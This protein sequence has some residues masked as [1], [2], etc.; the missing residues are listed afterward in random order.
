[1][2]ERMANPIVAKVLERHSL[3]QN[4]TSFC[5]CVADVLP[6][7]HAG[8]AELTPDGQYFE[9]LAEWSVDHTEIA[10]GRRFPRAGTVGDAVLRQSEHFVGPTREAVRAFPNTAASLKNGGFQSNFVARVRDTP[11]LVL[12][13]LSRRV[14]ALTQD[15]VAS[16][17]D[18]LNHLRELLDGSRRLAALDSYEQ[19]LQRD[20]ASFLSAYS[21]SNGRHPT[22]K[23]FENAYLRHLGQTSRYRVEGVLGGA[24][25]AGLKPSTLRYRLDRLKAHEMGD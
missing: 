25:L 2:A 1:M 18:S 5:G 19:R 8:L 22:L 16:L 4:F 13:V 20:V 6:I 7:H 24:S 21:E 15:G 10:P 9:V 14:A 12:Y 3:N 11:G 23:Q 17:V